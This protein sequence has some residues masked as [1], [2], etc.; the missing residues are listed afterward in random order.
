MLSSVKDNY[1]NLT[2]SNLSKYSS[3]VEKA[4]RGTLTSNKIFQF[5]PHD[6][7]WSIK[8]KVFAQ[9]LLEATEANLRSKKPTPLNPVH[10]SFCPLKKNRNW[11]LEL[12]QRVLRE[13]SVRS[14][15]GN[16]STIIKLRVYWTNAAWKSL[17]QKTLVFRKTHLRGYEVMKRPGSAIR[18]SGV[19]TRSPGSCS[20]TNFSSR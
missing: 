19:E 16:L 17:G 13:I 6:K 9:K 20:A 4:V 3:K 1:D 7:K 12:Q 2:K 15:S 14:T 11:T 5:S 18:T 8:D 10:V